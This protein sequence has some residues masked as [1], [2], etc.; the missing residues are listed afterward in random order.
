MKM[1]RVFFGLIKHVLLCSCSL[2]HALGLN[3]TGMVTMEA[4]LLSS[5]SLPPDGVQTDSV[6]MRVE[7]QLGKVILYLDS[8]SFT[9]TF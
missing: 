2:S 9:E 8:V 3:A 1:F 6:I 4:G 5:F 7:T